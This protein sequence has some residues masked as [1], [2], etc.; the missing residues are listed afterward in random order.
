MSLKKFRTRIDSIDYEILRLLH[1]R[2]EL[3][4]RTK[5]LKPGIQD[6][7]RETQ[8]LEQLQDYACLYG[9]L[10]KDFLE[11][12]Y[13]A[14]MKESRRIQGANK[15]LIGFQGE[16]GA[17]SEVASKHYD[18]NL[19]TLACSEFADVFEEIEL[20]Y[21]D[22]GIVP[23]E[24]SL[25]GAITE[26]NELLVRTN[27]K[28]VAGIKLR[29]NHCLLMLPGAQYRDIRIVYS[30][31]QALSQCRDFLSRHQLEARPF[32]DTA[33]AAKMLVKDKP[34][35]AAVIAN[36]RCAE[37]YNLEIIKENI[38]D[39]VGNFT[40]FLVLAKEEQ[41]DSVNKCSIIF[42]TPHKA[43]A[44]FEVLKIFADA[45]INLTRIESLPNREDPGSSVFFLDFQ[46]KTIRAQVKPILEKVK[47]KTVMLKS[48]GCYQEK[49]YE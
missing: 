23:V 29:I 44:L 34:N 17:F 49:V 24:N 26:V 3:G 11:S 28:V 12:L 32:Y 25:G 18:P 31:P 42:S 10:Q 41:K 14:I 48:L 36:A 8:I 39:N 46:S 35:M 13:P 37:L 22:M 47:E 2:I 5:R 19:V 15:L 38:Q 30:H 4:L 45:G 20:G 16:H 27:L 1:E 6:K 21:L 7:D 33:G 43:G 40:R 9:V